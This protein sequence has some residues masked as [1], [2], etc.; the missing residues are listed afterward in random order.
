MLASNPPVKRTRVVQ[1]RGDDMYGDLFSPVSR[2]DHADVAMDDGDID[3]DNDPVASEPI[4][5]R[6][7]LAIAD[8]SCPDG[9][10]RAQV[11]VRR[12]QHSPPPSEILILVRRASRSS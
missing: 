11:R 5:V 9:F 1:H 2:D 10:Q 6:I 4:Y 8:D 3:E 7:Y 12:A